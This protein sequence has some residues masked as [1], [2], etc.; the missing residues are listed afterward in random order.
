MQLKLNFN[1]FTA[2]EKLIFAMKRAF[3][4]S[5]N[6]TKFANLSSK[7]RQRISQTSISLYR[8]LNKIIS[9]HAK[10]NELLLLQPPLYHRDYGQA[11][12][13]DAKDSIIMQHSING[14][15]VSTNVLKSEDDFHSKIFS[16]AKHWTSNVN[17]DDDDENDEREVGN[18]DEM[19]GITPTVDEDDYDDANEIESD[20]QDYTDLS[21]FVSNADLKFALRQG[22][23]SSSTEKNLT[24]KDVVDMQRLAID[25]INLLEEQ[26]KMFGRTSISVD[27]E[28]KIRVI[29][30]SKCIG[31]SATGPRFAYRI[32]IENFNKL[33]DEEDA[34]G[35]NDDE[36]FTSVQLLG[37]TW[38][39]VDDGLDVSDD[40][41]DDSKEVIVD[42]PTTGAVGHLPVIHPGQVFEYMSGCELGSSEG[43]M[44]G[45][46]HMALVDKHTRSALVG[47]PV[48]AFKLPAERRFELPVAPFKLID[49]EL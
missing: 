6:I 12:I 47:D 3:S 36:N 27:E 2:S 13:I 49:E 18:F 30:V 7:E 5:A 8:I 32:R 10:K 43:H 1:Q 39:I 24:K 16:F 25:S 46:F 42:A 26:E 31:I 34:T 40:D 45:S 20:E 44:K 14:S 15:D 17:N 35:K 9:S 38:K 21:L 33:D 37:R 4:S 41:N 48:Q 11:R 28:R 23:K 22:F 19:F 29:A